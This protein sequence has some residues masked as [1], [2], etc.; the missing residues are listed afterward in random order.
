MRT[1]KTATSG[2]DRGGFQ[3]CD[4]H[5]AHDSVRDVCVRC[6][7]GDMF[8]YVLAVEDGEFCPLTCA[9]EREYQRYRPFVL[10]RFDE[11]YRER[12]KNKAAS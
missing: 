12:M 7:S 3:T 2:G 6:M 11:W 4:C 10:A 5:P 1:F 8:E 9:E